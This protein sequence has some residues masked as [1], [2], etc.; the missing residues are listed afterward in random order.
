MVN[1]QIKTW[2]S[3]LHLYLRVRL[4]ALKC[5]GET[6]SVTSKPWLHTLMQPRLSANQSVRTILVI[7]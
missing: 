3:V 2:K 5:A 6:E 4:T 7:L 1:L